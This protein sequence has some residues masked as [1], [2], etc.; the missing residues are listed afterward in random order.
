MIR[1]PG[2]IMI[3]IMM[4]ITLNTMTKMTMSITLVSIGIIPM[5]SG[6]GLALAAKIPREINKALDIIFKG[7]LIEGYP[8]QIFLLT[9]GDVSNTE[10][11]IR[12]VQ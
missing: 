2:V 1:Q 9:D 3:M 7:K 12:L 11:V 5:G 8:R 10:E 6:N 4:I